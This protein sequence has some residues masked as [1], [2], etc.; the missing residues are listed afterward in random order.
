MTQTAHGELDAAYR[1]DARRVYATLIRLLGGFQAA[2][3]GLH[4]AFLAAAASWPQ[5]G[6][7]ENPY[8]WLV[9]VGRNRVVDRWRRDARVRGAWTDMP[10]QADWT[11]DPDPDAIRDDDLRLIFICCHP[12]L[13]PDGRAALTLRE[14]CGLTTEEI[15]RAFLTPAPTIAQRIVRAKAKIRDLAIPYDVP[16][17]ADWPVRLDSVLQVIYLVFNE[18]HTA[19]DGP[20]MI[21]TDL[22]REAIRL[23]RLLN[24]LVDDAEALGLLA[25][26]LL[27][28]ARRVTRTDVAGDFVP[29]QEQ[30]RIRWDRALLAE[31][32]ALIA[33]ALT[34]RRAGPYILQAAI[35]ELHTSAPSLAATDWQQIVGLYDTLMRVAPS[36]V[37][38]LNRAVAIGQRDGAD[39]GLAAVEAAMAGGGLD[40]YHLAFTAMAG[41]HQQSGRIAKAIAFYQQGLNLA[42]RPTDRRFLERRIADLSNAA[43]R[44]SDPEPH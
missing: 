14:V 41:L 27:H 3:E 29:L 35:A 8:A 32:Q 1:N 18:G 24:D 34:H 23:G 15:A 13:S 17:R 28:D 43:G 36:P 6:I 22:C 9:S 20:D 19:T 7:P 12:A 26:M 33:R 42:V 4:E 21:R 30:D 2:E 37:V 25:L 11:D 39:A 40:A 44:L 31:A 38:A 16:G 5:N 10:V